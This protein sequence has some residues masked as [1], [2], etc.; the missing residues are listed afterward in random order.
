[1]KN[2]IT[3]NIFKRLFPFSSLPSFLFFKLLYY[4]TFQYYLSF[5]RCFKLKNTSCKD[6]YETPDYTSHSRLAKKGKLHFPTRDS[7]K[8]E[9]NVLPSEGGE[10]SHNPRRYTRRY[11]PSKWQ[12]WNRIGGAMISWGDASLR[13]SNIYDLKLWVGSTG[14]ISGTN[15]RESGNLFG[16]KV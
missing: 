4:S 16:K 14:A 8:V 5:P 12:E 11:T 3:K 6:Y 1:M 10:D 15:D 2:E 13:E 7:A 9:S